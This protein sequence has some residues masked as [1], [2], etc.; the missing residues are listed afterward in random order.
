LANYVSDEDGTGLVHNAPGFG[1]DD[2]LACKAYGIEPFAPIDN[3]GKFTKDVDNVPIIGVFYE[4]A[5]DI[6]IEQLKKLNALVHQSTINHP[7]AH[8]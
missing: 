1:N 6:I 5:N 3:Y 7:I 4:K 8:D 2:Y